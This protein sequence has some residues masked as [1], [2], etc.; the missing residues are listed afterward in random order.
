MN[1]TTTIKIKKE[2]LKRLN[3]VGK[4]EGE[5]TNSMLNRILDAYFKDT[6]QITLSAIREIVREELELIRR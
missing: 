2:T 1:D 4:R 6:E 5:T 3:K